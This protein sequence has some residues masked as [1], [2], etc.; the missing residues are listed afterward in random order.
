MRAGAGKAEIIAK[1][2]LATAATAPFNPALGL[3]VSVVDSLSLDQTFHFT[4]ADCEELRSGRVTC[5][6]A[7]GRSTARFDPL[8]AKPGR[9]RFSFR[10]KSLTLTEPF[11]PALVVRMTTDPAEAGTGVDRLG[12]LD[13]CRVTTKAML[14][15][16]KK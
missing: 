14:C 16:A 3:V 9:F 7:D 5:K 11:A 13:T 4:A 1:G 15:V 2:E 6:T 10:F 12:S 8:K